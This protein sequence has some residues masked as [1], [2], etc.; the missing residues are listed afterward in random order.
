M[1]ERGRREM[2]A[3]DKEGGL[4]P[5]I[6][7]SGSHSRGLEGRENVKQGSLCWGAFFTL[8]TDILITHYK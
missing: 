1:E 4:L 2:G 8:S 3:K 6:G 5:P 7:D